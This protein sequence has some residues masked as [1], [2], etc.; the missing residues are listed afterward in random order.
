MWLYC[1]MPPRNQPGR[2]AVG[3]A[4]WCLPLFD[5]LLSRVAIRNSITY[6]TTRSW[7]YSNSAKKMT[8]L[9][10]RMATLARLCEELQKKCGPWAA[11]YLKYEKKFNKIL[12][13]CAIIY[14][15]LLHRCDWIIAGLCYPWRSGHG[16]LQIFF[17]APS[18][19]LGGYPSLSLPIIDNTAD[20]PYLVQLDL[21]C[22]IYQEI[23]RSS[24]EECLVVFCCGLAVGIDHRL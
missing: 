6:V 18:A 11:A 14:G 9:S 15:Y 20:F 22:P 8:V 3:P 21:D 12:D 2:G 17:G 23:F 7:G 19:W 4:A 1:K 10:G 13:R 16:R 24:M 5:C